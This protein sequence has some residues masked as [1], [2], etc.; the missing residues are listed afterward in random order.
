M[1]DDW[2]SVRKLNNGSGAVVTRG[3]AK[4]AAYKDKDGEV[5]QYSG[6]SPL[7]ICRSPI[8]DALERHLYTDCTNRAV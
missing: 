1:G 3:L 7:H 8:T 5:H 6:V 2:A 4:V